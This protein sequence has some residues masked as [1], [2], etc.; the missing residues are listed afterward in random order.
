MV[1]D[2]FCQ[3]TIALF[4]FQERDCDFTEIEKNLK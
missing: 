2:S 1:N 3:L 4:F